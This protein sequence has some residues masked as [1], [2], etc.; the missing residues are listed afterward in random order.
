MDLIEEKLRSGLP[1]PQTL[2]HEQFHNLI[3]TGRVQ[4]HITEKTDGMAFEV[5]H[6]E[7]GPY[8]RTSHSDRMRH[9]GGYFEAAQKKFGADANPELSNRFAD[10]H[11]ALTGNKKLMGYLKQRHMETGQP[12][13][14]KGEIFHRASGHEEGGKVTFVGTS[15]DTKHMGSK[16][17]FV[18]HSKLPENRNH[19]ITHMHQYNNKEITFNHDIPD[20]HHTIDVDVSKQ[21]KDYQGLNHGLL[22]SRKTPKNKVEKEAEEGKLRGIAD[23]V[24]AKLYNVTSKIKPKW[25]DEVEGHVIHPHSENADAPR[26]KIMDY[27]GFRARKAEKGPKYEDV[28]EDW[29]Y[30]IPF[31]RYNY[32]FEGGNVKIGEQGAEPITA[33]KR[34]SRATD[35][36][37]MLRG[38][39]KA[40]NH[41]LFGEHENALKS[42][43]AFAGS[44]RHMMNTTGIHDREIKK[45]KPTFG[46]VDIQ[47]PHTS[48]ETVKNLLTPGSKHGVFTVIGSKASGNQISAIMK[49]DDGQHHQFDF[50]FKHYDPQTHEPTKLSQFI[51]NS[52]WDDIKQGIKGANH[53]M[54]VHSFNSKDGER[55][56][57]VNG[58]ETNIQTHVL[59]E[60]GMRAKHIPEMSGSKQKTEGGLPVYRE[61][62]PNEATYDTDMH[63]ITSKLIGKNA[64]P[65]DIDKLH[66]FGGSIELMKQHFNPEQ[67]RN[68]IK[69]YVH[70]IYDKGFRNQPDDIK[71]KSIDLLQHH[72]PEHFNKE[73][74]SYIESKKNPPALKEEKKSTTV[75]I[76]VGRFNGP[77]VEHEKLINKVFAQKADHH[78]IFVMGPKTVEQTSSKN[79]LTI[80]EKI[81]TLKKLYPDKADS[82]KSGADPA[83][84]SLYHAI[85]YSYHAHKHEGD[86]HLKAVGGSGEM[87]I[88]K[89]TGTGGSSDTFTNLTS[90][91]NGKHD[92]ALGDVAMDFKSV[93]SIPNERGAISG[94]V[95]RSFART[96][97]PK[98]TGHVKEFKSMLHSGLSHNDAKEIF[99]KIHSRTKDLSEEVKLTL[100]EYIPSTIQR[101]EDRVQMRKFRARINVMRRIKLTRTAS[102]PVLNVR[103]NRDARNSFKNK[104]AGLRGKSYYKL[105]YSSRI[106]IDTMLKGRA[107]LIKTTARR[108][109]PD[110]R[111]MDMTRTHV[112]EEAKFRI[113]NKQ[114]KRKMQVFYAIFDI[115]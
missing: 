89:G 113:D 19:D 8:T 17:M 11:N 109:L 71:V 63:S 38:M 92:K 58:K 55:K 74:N 103:A 102:L 25:G 95:V 83:H 35:I 54:L 18:V 67:Q 53:K 10:I 96:H 24:H 34:S 61:L 105:P 72:F 101:A 69:S 100:L 49:H 60:L 5:G 78:H 37:V 114:L 112:K 33:D 9:S 27:E 32:L 80:D 59:S 13:S 36:H 104:I 47:V 66:S 23:E 108:M 40:S 26:I 41:E 43:T 15:Y 77:T 87:G 85:S 12:A 64:T 21:L 86:V 28:R 56:G 110:V 111:K 6:D 106:A 4:G 94:S 75:A 20:T 115:V 91:Y 30:Y 99:D 48:K 39:N 81:N 57:I 107:A 73:M 42:G 1:H 44:T 51:Y 46:D 82:F 22:S 90:K 76:A 97:D 79:P 31:V 50:E 62:K 65:K 3:K 68:V 14:F 93:E 88:T 45:Y 98:N 29:R 7:N 70:K 84:K 16:G 52:H 2:K